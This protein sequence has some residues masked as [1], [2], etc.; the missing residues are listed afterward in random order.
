M[1]PGEGR[2]QNNLST[3]I[4]ATRDDVNIFSFYAYRIIKEQFNDLITK[5]TTECLM[6]FMLVLLFSSTYYK[7]AGTRIVCMNL[8]EIIWEKKNY[9]N[10]F[11]INT[12]RFS[13]FILEDS[14]IRNVVSTEGGGN[15]NDTFA[16]SSS[17]KRI[18][19]RASGP[20][21]FSCTITHRI[22]MDNNRERDLLPPIV[23]GKMW[24]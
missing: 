2:G 8:N 19:G 17:C 13:L 15:A 7:T 14:D 1:R 9:K 18:S 11:L 6:N 16:C 4:K 3:K 5:L 12:K 21:R 20:L 23:N 22:L 24:F 10:V